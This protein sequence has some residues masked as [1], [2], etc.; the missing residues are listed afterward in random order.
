MPVKQRTSIL[1]RAARF[2]ALVSLTISFSFANG[3]QAQAEDAESTSASAGSIR[4]AKLHA[5]LKQIC[6]D[7]ANL[8]LVELGDSVEGRPL[9]AVRVNGNGPDKAEQDEPVRVWC[10]AN[11]HPHDSAGIE[12][13]LQWL[14]Q[15]VLNETESLPAGIEAWLVPCANP[16]MH[17]RLRGQTLPEQLPPALAGYM[18]GNAQGRDLAADM[19]A[20]ET[21]EMQALARQWKTA[22]PDLLINVE[23]FRDVIDV[24]SANTSGSILFVPTYAPPW[25]S[26]GRWF[27]E[28]LLAGIMTAD[29]DAAIP[30]F[31]AATHR[32]VP[33][34][35]GREIAE[36]GALRGALAVSLVVQRKASPQVVSGFVQELLSRVSRHQETLR[37]RRAQARR[38]ITEAG[39]SPRVGDRLRVAPVLDPDREHDDAE[40]DMDRDEPVE[41]TRPFGYL[42]P[43]DE[44]RAIDRLLWHGIQVARLTDDT[45]LTVETYMVQGI[46]QASSPVDQAPVTTV[47]SLPKETEYKAAPGTFFIPTG[48]PLGQLV[49]HLLEPE[50]DLGLTRHR[51]FDQ[52]LRED[53]PHP[54]RRLLAPISLSTSDVERVEPARRLEL[55]DIYDPQ[56]MLPFLKAGPQTPT[57]IEGS[58]AYVRREKNALLR[59]EAETGFAELLYEPASFAHA[60]REATGDDEWTEENLP[61][62]RLNPPASAGLFTVKE[63]FYLWRFETESLTRLTS[64]PGRKWLATFSPNGRWLAFVH[65]HNLWTIDLQTQQARQLTTEGNAHLLCGE[66]DWVYQEE[67]YGRGNFRGYWWSPDSRRIAFLQSDETDVPTYILTDDVPVDQVVEKVAYPKSGD[68]L[69]KV[70]LGIISPLGGDPRWV[71]HPKYELHEHLI[72]RVGWT[73]DSRHVAYQVQDRPQT[74]LDLRT[75]EAASGTSRRVLREESPAWVAVLDEP[76]WLRDGSFLWLSDRSGQRHVYHIDANGQTVRQL[77]AGDGDVQTL[78][79]LD[80][81]ETWAYFSAA[82]GTQRAVHF[83]RVP[84]DGGSTERLTAQGMDHRVSPDREYRYFVDRRSHLH[85]PP[86]THLFR[87]NGTYLHA[88]DPQAADH[89][90]YYRMAS[91]E[92]L[93]VSA[94]DGEPLPSMLLPPL[95]FDPAKK[96]PVLCYVYG[97][98]QAPAVWNRWSGKRHLWHHLLSRHGFGIWTMD[99]RASGTRGIRHAWTIHHRM[100]RQELEDLEDSLDALLARGGADPQRIG[101]WGWSYGGYLT[102]YALTHSKK[103]AFGISGAPV[104][105]WHNYDAVYTERYMGLPQTNQEGYE[106]SS[107]VQ[108]AEHLHGRLLLIHGNIDDNVH[109]SNTWQF[110]EAM[111]NAGKSFELMLYP[112]NRHGVS[113]QQ[114]ARHLAELMTRFVLEQK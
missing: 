13:V 99:N 50:A 36:Y 93:E 63:D 81:E 14:E 4:Y 27:V 112:R 34:W 21:P 20:L 18:L 6:E 56:R 43:A 67:I 17:A 7:A 5:R 66:L 30:L 51:F 26:L 101:L 90:H 98:P 40:V 85:A 53:S 73:P 104:T 89:L 10:L 55:D 8:S 70:R 100:G 48:Q 24:D 22:P 110:V 114:Q 47:E 52:S 103:F 106:Q 88:V 64:F 28:D 57:W 41:V 79:G 108:A 2:V 37:E 75:A 92:F 80:A 19:P 82:W 68:P 74:W 44:V 33:A 45:H 12:G 77:T 78:H 109:P 3:F 111:Q 69:P 46:K 91:P 94:Q 29:F 39:T 32:D 86:E 11:V 31:D 71:R 107:V 62:L 58:N 113:R 87:C 102:A 97:G 84:L 72:V 23:A 35:R 60:L 76:H 83:Y 49:V 54:V 1:A 65:E 16:D 105:D 59:V 42:L 25:K 15:H 61:N 96:F 9:V 95:D 38:E